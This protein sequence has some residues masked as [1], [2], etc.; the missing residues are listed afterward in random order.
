MRIYGDFFH[1]HDTEEVE[2]LLEGV[3]H[4]HDAILAKLQQIN[5]SNYFKNIRVDEFVDGMF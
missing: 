1:K 3:T 5:F 2:K 4:N